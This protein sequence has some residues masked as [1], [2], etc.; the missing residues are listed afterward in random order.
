[1]DVLLVTLIGVITIVIIEGIHSW[2]ARRE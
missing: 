2:D 1:M